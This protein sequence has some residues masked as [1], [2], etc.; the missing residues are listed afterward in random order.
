VG[1]EDGVVCEGGG[2]ETRERPGWSKGSLREGLLGRQPIV[3]LWWE[4]GGGGKRAVGGGL[5]VV[6]GETG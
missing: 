3:G 6:M 5:W 4:V 2:P 1:W